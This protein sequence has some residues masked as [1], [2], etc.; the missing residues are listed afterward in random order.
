MPVEKL[1]ANPEHDPDPVAVDLAKV[2]PDSL[3]FEEAVGVGNRLCAL[4]S[5]G[6]ITQVGSPEGADLPGAQRRP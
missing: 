5:Y 2:T 3:P 4:S 1:T 6:S